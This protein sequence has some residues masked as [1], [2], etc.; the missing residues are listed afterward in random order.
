MN[1][2][3]AHRACPF[4][5]RQVPGA[6]TASI[7]IRVHSRSFVAIILYLCLGTAIAPC[8]GMVLVQ[9]AT[10]L[11]AAALLAHAAQPAAARWDETA[12][13]AAAAPA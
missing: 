11:F 12:A 9:R 10:F 7:L 6:D 5:I 4:P 3:V 13:T 2:V 8:I 1:T